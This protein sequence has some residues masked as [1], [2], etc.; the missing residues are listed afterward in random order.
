M[1]NNI[2]G[3][4]VGAAYRI[5][6]EKLIMKIVVLNA[7]IGQYGDIML[8]VKYPEV[9]ILR[10][11]YTKDNYAKHQSLI[12]LSLVNFILKIDKISRSL[13]R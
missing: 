9:G 11:D 13:S 7:I 5:I 1:F 4:N 12:K 2:L 6:S 3:E 8:R 10:L